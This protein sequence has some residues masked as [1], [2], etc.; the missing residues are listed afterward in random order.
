MTARPTG[1]AVLAAPCLPLLSGCGGSQ[2]AL[3]PQGFEAERLA[4]LFWLF[5]GV[6]GA[7]WGLVGIAMLTAITRRSEFVTADPLCLDPR[8]ERRAS[9][10]VGGLVSVTALILVAFTLLSY[11]ATRGLATTGEALGIEVTGYQWWWNVKYESPDPS[12]VFDTANEIH[13]PV[14]RPVKIE[15]KAA[16][17]IHSFWVPNLTG[18]QDLIPGQDNVLTFTARRAGRYRGQCAEFCGWQHAHMSFL[19]IAE[20]QNDFDAWRAGQIKAANS[21][22]GNRAPATS[23]GN[24]SGGEHVFM[25]RG[26][27]LCHTIRGTDAGGRAGPDLTHLASRSTLAAGTLPNTKQDLLAWIADPQAIKPGN[28]MPKVPLDRSELEAVGNYLRTLR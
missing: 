10:V 23:A 24:S 6:C 22:S 4:H 11:L 25:T 27:A 21:L 16:D 12:Q 9:F 13:V 17:V 19:V 18:K 15:L 3:N 28:K 20:S 7:V 26:C 14:G 8:R 1:W 5:T 2:S